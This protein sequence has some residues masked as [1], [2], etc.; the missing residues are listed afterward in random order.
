MVQWQ[1]TG[2]VIRSRRFESCSRTQPQG[3]TSISLWSKKGGIVTEPTT[4]GFE[5]VVGSMD[6][7]VELVSQVWT[8]MTSNAL[9]TLFLA[10][11]LISVGVSVFRMIK[12]AAKR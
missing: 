1:H 4:T 9:L 5:A 10:V 12:N 8:L 6:T 2:L 7:L 11:S 3:M